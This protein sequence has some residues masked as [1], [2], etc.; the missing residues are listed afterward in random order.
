VLTNLNT[1]IKKH[2]IWGHHESEYSHR[3][4]DAVQSGARYMQGGLPKQH[5]IEQ[6]LQYIF[7]PVSRYPRTVGTL[8]T[9]ITRFC[10]ENKMGHP[11]RF[12]KNSQ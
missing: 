2:D 10:K 12:V 9:Y 7:M 11:S 5:T 6:N 1:A 3:N 8:S 4:H